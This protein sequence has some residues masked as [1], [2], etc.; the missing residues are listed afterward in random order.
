MYLNQSSVQYEGFKQQ[1]NFRDRP[2]QAAP[3]SCSSRQLQI[4]HNLDLPVYCV[5][6]VK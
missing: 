6:A 4:R 5:P 2:V 1:V 3:V